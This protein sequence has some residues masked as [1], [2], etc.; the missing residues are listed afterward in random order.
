M[1]QHR[2]SIDVVASNSMNMID[3]LHNSDC[4][5]LGNVAGDTIPHYT[6]H[7]LLASCLSLTSSFFVLTAALAHAHGPS[8]C[9]RQ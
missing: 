5:K 3:L 2:A 1:S 9:P 4:G 7:C 6:T 8:R